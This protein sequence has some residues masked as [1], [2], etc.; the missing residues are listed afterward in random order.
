MRKDLSAVT[1]FSQPEIMNDGSENSV[2]GWECG[3]ENRMWVID[4]FKAHITQTVFFQLPVT[5]Q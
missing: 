4:T 3:N 5:I 2:E 1:Q